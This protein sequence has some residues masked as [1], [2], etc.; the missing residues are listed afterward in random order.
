M[1]VKHIIY[2]LLLM[3]NQTII[4]LC[5]VHFFNNYHKSCMIHNFLNGP[6]HDI[7]KCVSSRYTVHS[8]LLLIVFCTTKHSIKMVV[9]VVVYR[10]FIL[11]YIFQGKLFHQC[12]LECNISKACFKWNHDDGH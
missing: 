5:I 9:A 12:S 10:D 11:C 1:L 3:L 6:A 7:P 4:L 2:T 8:E